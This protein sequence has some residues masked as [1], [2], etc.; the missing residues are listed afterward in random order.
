M[1]TRNARIWIHLMFLALQAK[2]SSPLCTS[3]AS[4]GAL[5]NCWD[6]L[7]LDNKTFLTLVTSSFPSPKDQD[8]LIHELR[9]SR[10]FDVFEFNALI[11][12]WGCFLCN[13]PN[14]A[15][16]YLQNNE[17]VIEGQLKEK[18]SKWKLFRRWR[19]HYFTL[20]GLNLSYRETVSNFL[21][22]SPHYL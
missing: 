2:A 18:K 16:E 10:Y 11:N 15:E 12:I 9:S 21:F 7:K 20:S 17:P 13:H 6:T 22:F 5:K 19:T 14:R 3:E 8:I 4:V 1:R